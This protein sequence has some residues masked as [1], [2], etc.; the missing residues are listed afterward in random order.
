MARKLKGAALLAA[1]EKDGYLFA[2]PADVAGIMRRDIRTIYAGLERGEIPSVR[3]GQRYQI[4]LSWV[5]RQVDGVPEP[6]PAGSDQEQAQPEPRQRGGN[7]NSAHSWKR[8]P[9]GIR[10]DVPEDRLARPFGGAA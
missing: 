1:L 8:Q 2:S 5:R 9:G 7:P 10:R 6:R 4:S 3:V